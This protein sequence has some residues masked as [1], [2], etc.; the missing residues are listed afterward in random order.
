MVVWG[1]V[2]LLSLILI[3]FLALDLK[4]YTFIAKTAAF[5]GK[6][7]VDIEP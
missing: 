2:L 7:L 4:L 6:K 5:M 3:S 1:L